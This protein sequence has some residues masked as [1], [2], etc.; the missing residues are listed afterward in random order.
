[1]VDARTKDDLPSFTPIV[2]Q[3]TCVNQIYSPYSLAHATEYGSGDEPPKTGVYRLH[4][5]GRAGDTIQHNKEGT[6]PHRRRV[7]IWGTM[8]PR[9]RVGGNRV[10]HGSFV[11]NERENGVRW[12]TSRV[13]DSDLYNP[14]Q[15]PSLSVCPDIWHPGVHRITLGQ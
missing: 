4:E 15:F 7:P 14:T 13:Y 1:M 9:V 8:L 12:S 5:V 6:N 10:G 3:S 11:K 2:R